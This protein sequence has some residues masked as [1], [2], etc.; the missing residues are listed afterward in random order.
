MLLVPF[1]E[2][3]H[4]MTQLAPTHHFVADLSSAQL[5]AICALYDRIWPQVGTSLELRRD[6]LRETWVH[7]EREVYAFWD[8]ATPLA[9]S[10][11][12]PRTIS[13]SDGPLRILALAG[14]CSA[15]EKRGLGLGAAVVR[16]AFAQVAA[17]RYGVALYQTGVP[18]FY[19]KL[20][21]RLVHNPFINSR[22]CPGDKGSP[23]NPW[24]EP[25]VMIYPAAASWPEGSID[26]CGPGY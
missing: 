6:V 11:V 2:G 4:P 14:V 17:G 7:N 21:A 20:G 15:P 12:F 3:I 22:H 23:D 24:W 10:M 9:L 16:A 18:R 13:T 25:H 26:L 5:R 8:D 1:S 19:E